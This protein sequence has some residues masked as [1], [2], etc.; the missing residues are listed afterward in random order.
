MNLPELCLYCR[1]LS[2]E[3]KQNDLEDRRVLIQTIVN[4]VS[5]EIEGQTAP[6]GSYRNAN[7]RTRAQHRLIR[8]NS[9]TS[10]YTTQPIGSRKGAPRKKHGP[11]M[12]LI[13]RISRPLLTMC[14]FNSAS[15]D[16]LPSVLSSAANSCSSTRAKIPSTS[17]N[18]SDQT[19]P[20]RPLHPEPCAYY[21]NVPRWRSWT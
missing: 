17:L 3:K 2:A 18:Y 9:C 19:G 12:N 10:H 5:E 11:S 8:V 7:S 6:E 14:G 15:T 4:I 21:R 20:S 13:L 16:F 1:A